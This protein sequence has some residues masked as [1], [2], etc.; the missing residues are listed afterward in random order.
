MVSTRKVL[1]ER[2]KNELR[3][4]DKNKWDKYTVLLSPPQMFGIKSEHM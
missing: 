4:Q 2:D 1:G 3:Y